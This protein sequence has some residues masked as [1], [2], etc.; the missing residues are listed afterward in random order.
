MAFWIAVFL[1]IL[2]IFLSQS[3][4]TVL[5]E[6]KLGLPLFESL[7]VTLESLVFSVMM[8]LRLATVISAFAILS[9]AVSPEEIMS[10]MARLRVPTKSVFITSL[11]ARLIP[12][13]M[14][15]TGTLMEVQRS[16]GAKLKGIR[17]RGAV[18]IPLLSNS[19]ERS[20]S[21]AE[22]MEAR[23]FDGR[24]AFEKND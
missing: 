10:V 16:R 22:A 6:A 3:G 13:L 2:N 20:V 9:L 17:G 11:S 7:R 12:S 1:I 21:V 18:V 24:F 23:G 19:L 5:F 14:E 15:D 4:K 8:S